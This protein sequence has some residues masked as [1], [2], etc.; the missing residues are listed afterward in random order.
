[1]YMSAQIYLTVF[2]ASLSL[3]ASQAACDIA[4]HEREECVD[5]P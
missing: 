1:M 4:V 5:C 3:L 2:Q